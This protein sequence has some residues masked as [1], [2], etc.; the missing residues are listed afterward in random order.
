LRYDPALYESVLE[1]LRAGAQTRLAGRLVDLGG[2][3]IYQPA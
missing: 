3:R 2:M 1:N